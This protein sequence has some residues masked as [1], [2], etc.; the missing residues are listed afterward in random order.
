MK[1]SPVS[2]AISCGVLLATICLAGTDVAAQA[3]ADKTLVAR[4]AEG[5]AALREER[6][7]EAAAIYAELVGQRPS[8]AGLLMNLGMAR[9]MA[10]DAAGAVEPLQKALGS[11]PRSAP[12]R[13]SSAARCSISGAYRTR[14]RRCGAP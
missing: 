6:F 2:R 3:P 1:M 5:A 9:Y 7:D 11:R 14:W 4:A 13:C 12:R 10:G 8:D